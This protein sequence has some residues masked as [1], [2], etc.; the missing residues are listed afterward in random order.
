MVGDVGLPR[1]QTNLTDRI[2]HPLWVRTP[3]VHGLVN[4]KGWKEFTMEPGTVADAIVSQLLKGE[5]A[6]LI[7][8]SR[9]GI[10]S[11]VRGWPSWLQQSLRD[12]GA[13]LLQA[14]N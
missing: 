14:P 10:A 4:R 5:S 8:P 7:L 9:F 11:G 6:Q 13:Q 12:R 1:T 3:L 2:V